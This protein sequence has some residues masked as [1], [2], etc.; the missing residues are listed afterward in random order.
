[1]VNTKYW[2]N[3]STGTRRVLL[4]PGKR[5]VIK[6]ESPEYRAALEQCEGEFQTWLA[7]R[8]THWEK[9]FPRLLAYG[10]SGDSVYTLFEYVKALR[11]PAAYWRADKLMDRLL[12]DFKYTDRYFDRDLQSDNFGVTAEGTIVFLD[13]GTFHLQRKVKNISSAKP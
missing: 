10:T 2:R 4:S 7:V 11:S 6:I 8:G 1:M 3:I 12:K 9:H 5:Y 13:Y